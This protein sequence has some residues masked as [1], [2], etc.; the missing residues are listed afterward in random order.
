[1]QWKPYALRE[2]SFGLVDRRDWLA[3]ADELVSR[4]PSETEPWS[5][6]IKS[7]I[8]LRRAE[9]EAVCPWVSP[10][11]FSSLSPA[12]GERAGVRGFA[13]ASENDVP[14][15]PRAPTLPSP[16]PPEA[17]GE[18][19][20]TDWHALLDELNTPSSVR[21]WA[22]R[23]PGLQDELAAWAK[24]KPFA[25]HEADAEAL[26]D[27]VGRS[28]APELVKAIDEL[29]ASA[30]KYADAMDFHFLY[31]ESRNLFAIGYN[32]P[33]ERLD[34]AHYDLLASEAAITSF[35]AVARGVVPRKHWFQLG[36]PATRA[37]GW[38]G[39]VSWGGT[40]FEYLMPRLLLPAPP[41]TLL[42]TAQRAAVARHIEYGRQMRTP[43][44]ISES[45]F[46]VVDA[47]ALD[48]Q[49]Q[50][51]GVP[52]LGLKRGLG[53]DLVIAPYATML[54]TPVDARAAVANFAAIRELGGEGQY[55]FY[56]ALD[57]TPDRLAKGERCKVVKSYMAHHQ[58]MGL[59]AIANRLLGDIHTRRLR[60]EPS[61]RAV[62]L[63]LHERVPI[64]AP[65][66]RSPE[67]E[68]E[69]AG[70]PTPDAVN[71][72]LTRADTPA[73]RPHILSNGHYT[74]MVTNAGSGL[75]HLPRP[76]GDALAD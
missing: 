76:G 22:E 7:E 13:F 36:R 45:G 44:G 17:G 14:T 58:G 27:A 31:N 72:R 73:P 16:F 28:A 62:E 71:R 34:P 12:S 6:A 67:A 68:S 10:V 70:G 3:K 23:L 51:F 46:Y 55:G 11:L 41:G 24:S 47:L 30:G 53:K 5:E 69:S 75:Q 59:C 52:G 37:A 9:L 25:G 15:S 1:M 21:Y 54:A 4:L 42:D 57:F 32:V 56:E 50:S 63:L 35:L 64:D 48:Y 39:L 18:G 20:K 26:A 8:R 40:M 65:E 74:V 2:G 49:Y 33:L 61:V 38:P 29:I 66:I 43:W 60:A 19:N